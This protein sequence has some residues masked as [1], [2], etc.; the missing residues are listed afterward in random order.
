MAV[1]LNDTWVIALGL[2]EELG[3]DVPWHFIPYHG[4]NIHLRDQERRYRRDIKRNY[5]TMREKITEL[6]QSSKTFLYFS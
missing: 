4:K 1:N 2:R 3:M 6:L 5:P